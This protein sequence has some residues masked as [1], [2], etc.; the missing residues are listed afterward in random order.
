M[1]STKVDF[2]RIVLL[3]T[4]EDTGLERSFV[5]SFITTNTRDLL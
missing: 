4:L 5:L 1:P 2:R 3:V